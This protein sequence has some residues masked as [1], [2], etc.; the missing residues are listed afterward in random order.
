V[1]GPGAGAGT[2]RK[3]EGLL[4]NVEPAL[5]GEPVWNPWTAPPGERWNAGGDRPAAEP[6]APPA[7]AGANGHGARAAS[8]DSASGSRADA[9]ASP[10]AREARGGSAHAP[11]PGGPEGDASSGR[12]EWGAPGGADGAAPGA[13]VAG[14]GDAAPGEP[15]DW[16]WG[17]LSGAGPAPGG[18]PGATGQ[19][20]WRSSAWGDGAGPAPRGADGAGAW[21]DGAGPAAGAGWATGS[22]AGARAT[23]RQG[24]QAGSGDAYSER[25]GGGGDEYDG[26]GEDGAA[27]RGG[28]TAGSELDDEGPDVAEMLVDEVVRR[29]P[30][31]SSSAAHPCPASCGGAAGMLACT[32]RADAPVPVGAAARVPR[33]GARAAPCCTGSGASAWLPH[34]RNGRVD[35]GDPKP[36]TA[37]RRSGCCR[38]RPRRSRC[39]SAAATW[40]RC[41]SAW[42]C[43]RWSRWRRSGRPR[44]P[45]AR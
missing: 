42:A 2:P 12:Q 17:A 21:G 38:W 29:K 11:G 6:A 8:P 23:P 14:W 3:R 22:A 4:D 16:G 13:D 10:F 15:G 20:G 26:G 24:G 36:M 27:W 34:H 45:P 30:A 18:A 9:A 44:S 31:Y 28:W 41:G 7:A 5:G 19:G 1:R 33:P 35:A 37:R 43:R 40:S 25:E 32:P 39:S